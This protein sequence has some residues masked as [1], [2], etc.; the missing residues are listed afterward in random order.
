M[1]DI[2]TINTHRIW[3]INRY[4]V[5]TT[6]QIKHVLRA[7][8]RLA[9]TLGQARALSTKVAQSGRRAVAREHFLVTI[10]VNGHHQ[11]M[12]DIISVMFDQVR[13][14]L[15]YCGFLFSLQ[16]R[17]KCQ[18]PPPLKQARWLG[19]SKGW[20]QSRVECA[21]PQFPQRLGHTIPGA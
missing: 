17:D 8:S 5:M 9:L 13:G 12:D 16:S 10:G 14:C 18:R 2:I 4:G 6:E 19:S 3:S 20:L 21:P 7:W 15:P 11:R 1:S